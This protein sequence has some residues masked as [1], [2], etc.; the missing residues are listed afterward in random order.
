MTISR[1]NYFIVITTLQFFFHLGTPIEIPER[2]P[3]S[4]LDNK[5]IGGSYNNLRNL[6]NEAA[7]IG[8]LKDRMPVSQKAMLEKALG[9]G[10]ITDPVKSRRWV[11]QIWKKGPNWSF[12]C[13]SWFSGTI[14]RNTC[15]QQKKTVFLNFR[16][17]RRADTT[18]VFLNVCDG[19]EMSSSRQNIENSGSRTTETS[20]QQES[21]TI[22]TTTEGES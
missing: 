12:F 14:F 21:Q 10:G 15:K 17:Y 7:Q 5:T 19:D 16:R 11:G 2:R 4:Q 18:P 9:G 22:T 1:W 13:F 3:L 20:F 6:S 8:S